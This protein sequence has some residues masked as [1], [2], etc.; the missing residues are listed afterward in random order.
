MFDSFFDAIRTREKEF[1]VYGESEDTDIT[2]QFASHNV[3]VTHRDLP[4]VGLEAFLVIVEGG[5]FAGAIALRDLEGLLTPPIVRPGANE[6]VSRGYRALF[7]VVDNTLFRS[8][9]RRELLAVTR[10][11]E[12]RAFRVGRGTLRVSFQRLSTFRSQVD[13][14]RHLAGDTDLDVHVYGADDWDPPEIEGVVYHGTHD[15]PL[16]RHWAIAFDGG[17]TDH[18][19]ALVAR[20]LSDGYLGCWTDDPRLVEE[21]LATLSST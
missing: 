1:I 2:A 8:M 11:I 19:C 13:V 15:S 5:E 3:T 9:S 7:E 18:A 21:V 17:G 20:E 14:Y 4:G 16:E 6:G 12:D 10:E